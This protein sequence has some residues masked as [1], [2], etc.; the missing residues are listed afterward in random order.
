MRNYDL[1]CLPETW[2]AQRFLQTPKT[3]LGRVI[4][5]IVLKILMM[6]TRKPEYTNLDAKKEAF[7]STATNLG[8]SLFTNRTRP[9][10]YRSNHL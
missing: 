6:Q 10:Y 7:A 5:N 1:T 4:T 2:L 9:M 3:C 8:H